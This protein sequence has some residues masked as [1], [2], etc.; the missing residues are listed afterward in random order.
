MLGLVDDQYGV[1]AAFDG[2]AADLGVDGAVGG[3]AVALHR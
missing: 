1:E 2:Q 3:G